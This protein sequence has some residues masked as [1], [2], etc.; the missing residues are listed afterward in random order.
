MSAAWNARE[1]WQS[2]SPQGASQNPGLDTLPGASQGQPLPSSDE[3]Q[4]REQRLALLRQAGHMLDAVRQNIQQVMVGKDSAIDALLI[5]L[6]SEGH[7]LVEDVPGIGKST[8][9]SALARSLG[10]H[11]R[12]I[13]FTPDVMPSD[14]TG[15]SVYNQHSANFDFHEGLLMSE[16][17]LAD[18]LNRATPKTQS[19]LLEAMQERQLSVDG[20]SLPLPQPFLVLATQNPVEQAGTYP[21]PE[22]QLDRFCLCI[23]LG[24]PDLAD[25]A[26]IYRRHLAGQNE[27]QLQAVLQKEDVQWLQG[28][29]RQIYVADSLHQYIAQ[30]AAASRQ[31]PEL[32]LGASPR[33]ALMLLRAS[34]SRALLEGRGFV[35]PDDCRA[36]LDMCWSHRLLLTPDA[37]LSGQSSSEQIE[38]LL[39]QV[40]VPRN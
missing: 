40:P 2:R 32:S 12:R 7:A 18:E 17:V 26:E 19:A 30:L 11:F 9:V 13:Q 16:I 4:T 27:Q 5:V 31:L 10:L 23:K 33:A 34:Q 24:Y 25:E 1:S 29:S 3:K 38:R 39:Q 35:T 37:R 21:L 6:L 36:L 8:L 28:L 20:K 15:Y 22:A 14:L